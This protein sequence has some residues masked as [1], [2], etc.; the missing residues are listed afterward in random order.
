MYARLR[1]QDD[2]YIE[3]SDLICLLQ[4]LALRWETQCS[5]EA[6]TGAHTPAS[7]WILTTPMQ[8]LKAARTDRTNE[9]YIQ[10]GGRMLR[11]NARLYVSDQGP[12]YKY[13]ESRWPPHYGEVESSV[14][15]FRGNLNLPYRYIAQRIENPTTV[16]PHDDKKIGSSGQ[17]GRSRRGPA[18]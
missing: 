2:F 13:A 12:A 1:L 3:G 5:A 14:K 4:F 11:R 10:V 9:A 17:N 8:W 6:L 7:P 15:A 16:F 18:R